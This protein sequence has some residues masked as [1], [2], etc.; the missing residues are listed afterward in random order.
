MYVYIAVVNNGPGPVTP[1]SLYI[2]PSWPT[3]YENSYN[4]NRNSTVP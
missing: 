4:R 3:K 1:W 2:G